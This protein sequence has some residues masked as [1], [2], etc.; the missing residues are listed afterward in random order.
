MIVLMS[1]CVSCL[2]GHAETGNQWFLVPKLQLGNQLNMPLYKCC[3]VAPS[4][5]ARRGFFR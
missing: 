3:F 1:L 4:N 5:I 2:A